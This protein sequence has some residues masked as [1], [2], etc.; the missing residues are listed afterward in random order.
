MSA[1]NA[2]VDDDAGGP[3]T[4]Q[5]IMLSSLSELMSQLKADATPADYRTAVVEDNVL[6]KSTD[7]AR[8]WA[9][10]QMRRFY[11]LDPEQTLFRALRDLWAAEVAGQPLLALLCALA[12]DPVL[13]STTGVILEAQQGATVRTTDIEAAIEGCHPG[14]YAPSTLKTTAQNAS[15]S[16]AQSGHLSSVKATEKIRSQATSTPPTAAYALL[17]GHLEGHRGQALL[18]T[19]WARLLDVS[20][21]GVAELAAIAAQQG[22]VEMRQGGGVIEVGFR[23]LLRPKATEEAARGEQGQLL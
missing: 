8:Q 19:R 17:L 14:R 12:R 22:F 20:P 1:A 4:S 9:F 3:I 7:G 23:H 13:R 5:T 2:I 6:G 21:T 16:W 10:R 18:A 11:Q 15:S